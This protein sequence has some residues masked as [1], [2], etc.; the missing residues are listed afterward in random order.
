M[1]ALRKMDGSEAPD[2]YVPLNI[3]GTH[4]PDPYAPQQ[5]FLGPAWGEVRPFGEAAGVMKTTARLTPPLGVLGGPIPAH[6][7][8]LTNPAWLAELREAR[9]YGGK[10]GTNGLLRTPEQT[11]V[12][13]FWGYDGAR[14][15]GVPPRL[16]NQCLQA[17]SIKAAFNEE[18][19][20]VLFAVGNMAMA[21]A[22]IAA[23]KSKYTYQDRKSVV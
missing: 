19:N 13:T 1:L 5:G 4:R 10:A 20:A 16:Y 6:G 17:I 22:G 7:S 11:I 8:Y 14:D 23:W 21:D 9:D 2:Q 12:G 18:Q 15:I 3:P